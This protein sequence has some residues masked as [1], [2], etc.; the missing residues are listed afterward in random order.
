MIYVD[1][2]IFNQ[3]N[4][5]ELQSLT[6]HL[7]N[8]K[9]KSD[10]LSFTWTIDATFI[11]I[12]GNPSWTIVIKL[13][14]GLNTMASYL[15]SRL[16]IK[17][18]RNCNEDIMITGMYEVRGSGVVCNIKWMLMEIKWWIFQWLSKAPSS[19]VLDCEAGWH[20][21]AWRSISVSR[22]GYLRRRSSRRLARAGIGVADSLPRL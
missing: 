21:G 5:S 22:V 1:P 19:E 15:R 17:I 11:S 12:R 16:G 9:L 7:P 20:D 14:V 10:T 2:I 8:R 3:L 13:F 4:H 18:M 6:D